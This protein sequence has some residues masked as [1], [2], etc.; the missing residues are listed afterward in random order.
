MTRI[1]AGVARGR[2][3]DVP[4]TGTRPTSDRVREAIFSSLGHRLGN[5]S[6]THVLDLYAGT[7]ALS[8]EA[9]SRGAT[10]ATAVEKDR[11]A[12]D[13]IR[14]NSTHLQ[15]PLTVVCDDVSRHLSRKSSRSFDVV[16]LDPPYDMDSGDLSRNLE[17]LVSNEFVA[18]DSVLVIE[19]SRRS[20]DLVFPEALSVVDNRLHGE[21]RVITAVW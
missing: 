15:L 13:V 12:C 4:K 18:Q 5:W 2:S 8:F 7:A 9:L 6:N 10:T 19:R 20:P 16:F 3:I 1:I 11:Q 14:K 17:L 21:T